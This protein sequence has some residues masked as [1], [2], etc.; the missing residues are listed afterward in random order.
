MPEPARSAF[1]IVVWDD[2]PALIAFYRDV[3]GGELVYQFPPEGDPVYVSIRLGQSSV[4]LGYE[5]EP[6]RGP[7]RVSVWV[8]VPDVDAAVAAAVAAGAPVL[9][10]AAD[11]PWGE[12]TARVQDPAGVD[13]IL[14][15]PLAG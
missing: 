15:A 7:Q 2:L 6:P 12:R 8:Y 9:E 3:L 13:V 5:P 11:Q 4:G 10:E 14:G 1:P